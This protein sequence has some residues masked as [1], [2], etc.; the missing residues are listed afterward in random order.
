VK[1]RVQP[2]FP[3]AGRKTFWN[4]AIRGVLPEKEK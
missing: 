3:A 4:S 2:P 1:T